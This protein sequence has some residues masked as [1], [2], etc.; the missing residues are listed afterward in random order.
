[1]QI[2]YFDTPQWLFSSQ[3][4]SEVEKVLQK[5]YKSWAWQKYLNLFESDGSHIHKRSF[6]LLS[7][8]ALKNPMGLSYIL[9]FL[10]QFSGINV[11]IFYSKMIFKQSEAFH[12]QS[13]FIVIFISSVNFLL[14]L[15]TFFFIKKY[16]RK[17]LLLQGLLG[18]SM[19]FLC[20][21]LFS[22][23]FEENYK[24]WVKLGFMLCAIGFY[25]TSLGP[26]IWIY[27]TEILSV[28]WLGNAITVQWI[29]AAAIASTYPVLFQF[30]YDDDLDIFF[31]S[32]SAICFF[33]FIFVF[34]YAEESGGGE[35][36]GVKE[37]N[38]LNSNTIR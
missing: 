6:P 12:R 21:C 8:K 31:A 32:C 1:M 29:S 34:K 28:A 18:M 3:R 30:N 2:F 37:T 11:I 36:D 33:G 38:L 16:G 9:C 27:I 25:E 24:N 7:A 20:Y 23:F 15:P 22:Y 10:Q 14:V 35:I 26:V 4:I 17:K 19:S 13:S 5:I